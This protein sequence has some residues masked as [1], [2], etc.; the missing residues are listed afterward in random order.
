MRKFAGSTNSSRKDS[1]LLSFFGVAI[2]IIEY[3]KETKMENTL[4][5]FTGTG[6]SLANARRLADLLGEA[7][8]ISMARALE[9]GLEPRGQRIGLLFPTYAYGLPRMVTDFVQSMSFPHDAYVF[10]VGSS[11]GIPG[12]VLRQLDRLLKKQGTR[13]HAGFNV[14]DPRSSL[15]E[16]PDNDTVQRIMIGLNRGQ[17]PARSQDRIEEIAE[18]VTAKRRQ[19]PESSNWPTSVVGGLLNGFAVSSFKTM[20][21]SFSAGAECNACGTCARVCPRSNIRIEDGRPLWGSDCEMCHACIQWCPREAIQF[22]DRT[23]DKPR[24]R[25]PQV[26]VTDMMMR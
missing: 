25:N 1:R 19:S 5:Y 3:K 2:L 6:N 20:A 24:Y 13:L 12:R 9:E 18:T 21:Q 7:R 26:S 11:F 15:I 16:D 10:A 8:V 17:T 4:Y 22:A 14:L 23:E